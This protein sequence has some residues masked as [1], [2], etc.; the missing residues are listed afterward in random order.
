M[1]NDDALQNLA[2]IDDGKIKIRNMEYKVLILPN[3]ETI[4]LKTLQF[5]EKYVDNGGIVIAL[6]RLPEKSTGL[7][8]YKESDQKVKELTNNL[9]NKPKKDRTNRMIRMV[10]PDPESWKAL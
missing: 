8:E 5:I 6:E 3:V 2:K 1:I 7:K 4:P 9:F 10:F